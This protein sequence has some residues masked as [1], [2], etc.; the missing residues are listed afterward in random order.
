MPA[1]AARRSSRRI[2]VR[3]AR[4]CRPTRTRR[5]GGWSSGSRR[6]GFSV[7][8]LDGV[9]GSGKT[10]TYFAAI[11]AALAAGRQVLVLL[12]EIAL[13]AQWLERFRRRFGA[14]AGR[15]AFRHHARPQRRDTWRAVADGPGAGRRRR[16]LGAV[17]A[18]P[19]ARADRRRRG[20]RPLLQAGGRRLLS[21][22]RHGGAARLAGAD[23]DR[24]GVGDAVA[25]NRRQRRARP[26]RAGRTAAPPRRGRAA[27]GRARSTCGASACEPG[28]FLSPPLVAALAADAGGRRAGA[29]VP[30]PPR[31]CAADAVPRLRPPLPM[32][33]LHR[34]AG[35]A[36]L[37]RAAAMPSLRLCRRRCRRSARNASRPARWCRAGRGSSACSEE[38]AARFPDGAHR[39]DGQRPAARPARRR[40]ARRGDDRAPLR[41]ADRHPDR[42][43][44][45]S[46]PDAD[47][48][49]R[50]R[51]R[52]RARRRRSARRRAHLSAAAPGR[53]PRRPRRAAGPGAAPDL[54]ARAAGDA[55]A[56]RRRPRPLSRSRGG[57]AARRAGCR[58]SA[59][60]R[61]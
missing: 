16:A 17:P 27:A 25:R 2:G 37:Y 28:R 56:R 32:P 22:A 61:R 9:T 40:R 41:C 11:A 50:G 13:G 55:G 30:Q 46:F 23:P 49:R 19:R 33:E 35:R 15:M 42:R 3:R 59:G 47:P 54:H 34:L 44:G 36:P 20:A 21:G 58:R 24:A 10:E 53:R 4:P 60:S 52:S 57:G 6:G 7:T 12:P 26:L 31:L 29:A 48:G 18:V 43:Q 51:R 38:V 14:I 1:A 39:A 8:V 45:P 5:R